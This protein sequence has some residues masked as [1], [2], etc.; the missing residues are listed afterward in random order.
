RR[1]LHLLGAPGAGGDL[2]GG[3]GG[4]LHRLPG[5]VLGVGVAGR[6][7]ALHPDPEPHGDP[8]RRGLE[9]PF[10]EREARPGPV[11]E[12]EVGVCAAPGEGDREEA[13]AEGWVDG[14]VSPRREGGPVGL[15]ERHGPWTLRPKPPPRREN[16]TARPGPSNPDFMDL[17]LTPMLWLHVLGN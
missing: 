1:E 17:V 12:E 10:V 16:V 8:A 3:L 7:A 6:V 11:L 5:Q 13:P 9:D 2:G 4:A 14:T 15:A